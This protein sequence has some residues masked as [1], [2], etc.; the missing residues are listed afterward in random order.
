MIEFRR[1]HDDVR[2]DAAAS[3]HLPAAVRELDFRRM[4]RNFALIVIFVQR[5]GFVIA[6]NQPSAGCVVTRRSQRKAGIFAERLNGAA[7]SLCR[8][9]FRQQ[10]SPDHDPARLQKQSPLPRPEFPFHQDDQRRRHALIAARIARSTTD[11]AMTVH[12]AKRSADFYQGTYRRRRLLRSAARRDCRAYR[13]SKPSRLGALSRFKS[14][15][16]FVVGRFV[17]AGK[18]E[19]TPTPG[20]SMN[21]MSTECRGNPLVTRYSKYELLIVAFRGVSGNQLYNRSL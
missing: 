21:A 17:E 20:L 11:S 14:F 3:R 4:L 16:D 15:A 18:G 7:P 10:S 1:G 19:C 9:S 12:G 13:G 6:L 5:N 8:T 2:R